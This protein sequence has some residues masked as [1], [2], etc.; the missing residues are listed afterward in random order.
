MNSRARLLAVLKGQTPDRVPISTYELVGYNSRAWE[1]QEPSYARLM[2]TIRAKTDCICMWNPASNVG[3]LASAYPA[4]IDVKTWRE[5]HTTI[6]R[7]TIHTPRGDL[8]LTTKVL[9]G[10][11]TTWHVERP[12]KSVADVD[13]ALSVP[14]VPLD[15]DISDY[16][17][18][19][20]EVGDH[21]IIMASLSDPL[22]MAAELMEFGAYTVWAMTETAHFARTVEVMRERC[23]EN[24][25]RMLDA[26]VVDVYRIC[27]PEYATPPYLPP[28]FFQR[29]VV[30]Y[31]TAMVDLIHDYGASV[32]F[33]CH[34]KIRQVLPMIVATGADGLDP[35]EGP[36]DGDIPL[37]ALKARLKG[38]GVSIF[39][40]L[41][42]KLLE[43]GT[44]DDVENAVRACMRAAKA[45][46]GYVIMPTAAPINIPLAKRTEENYLRF[47]N[48]A[49]AY[50]AY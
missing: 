13:K 43:H 14:Y 37:A 34:G 40:N 45:G 32:R 41:Q 6:T 23:M 42:L 10:L 27:G 28:A 1:N 5:D 36:P 35:C 19:K 48:T 44:A 49:L 3:F 47:I 16:V 17:R 25:R 18:I 30:P 15:Y 29:F 9:D 38:T 4:P 39:G 50:G 2:E 21:G 26:N 20:R 46:S 33:H 7:R 8:T 31:V 11:H 22:L 24:L 12:C